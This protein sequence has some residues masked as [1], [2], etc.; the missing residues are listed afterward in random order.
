MKEKI[1]KF[2]EELGNSAGK[3]AKRYLVL[4]VVILVATLILPFI[5]RTLGVYI[6]A[7]WLIMA[8]GIIYIVGIFV[9]FALS[10]LI[11]IPVDAILGNNLLGK[12]VVRV[13]GLCYM[14]LLVTLF[15]LLFLDKIRGHMSLFPILIIVFLMLY[16]GSDFLN[17]KI[18]NPILLVIFLGV[19][20]NLMAPGYSEHWLRK[21]SDADNDRAMERVQPTIAQIES[22]NFSFV[23]K[24]TGEII[25]WYV[26]NPNTGEVELYNSPGTH[27]TLLIV[28]EPV[29]IEK[30]ELYKKQQRIREQKTNVSL[31]KSR[32]K[33]LAERERSRYQLAV[34]IKDQ[35][36]NPVDCESLLKSLRER[37]ISVVESSSI[38]ARCILFGKAVNDLTTNNISGESSSYVSTANI[39]YSLSDSEGR[40]IGH[41]SVIGTAPSF[42]SERA[43]IS[44]INDALKKLGDKIYQ[45]IR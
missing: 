31:E 20:I 2:L 41:S 9:L 28:A 44:A 7:S 32:E 14:A 33:D 8:G 27:P 19:I 15:L 21:F 22:G 4:L 13:K 26:Q 6:N 11:I 16:A 3:W 39:T 42:S 5:L 23:D 29:N 18:V 1:M 34:S 24:R 43:K 40:I 12:V 38:N 17:R 10:L 35:N 30:I 25:R 37:N 45:Q 36:G